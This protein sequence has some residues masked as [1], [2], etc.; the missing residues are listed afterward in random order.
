MLTD[1]Q[2]TFSGDVIPVTAPYLYSIQYG[3]SLGVDVG[4]GA[5]IIRVEKLARSATT[6][7]NTWY[8]SDLLIPLHIR[9]F[10]IGMVLHIFILFNIFVT[11]FFFGHQSKRIPLAI[12]TLRR[13]RYIDHTIMLAF[14]VVFKKQRSNQR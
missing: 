11:T 9:A 2:G 3:T 4:L 8:C 12:F 7:V 14:H 5:M 1:F 13:P 6:P 10:F